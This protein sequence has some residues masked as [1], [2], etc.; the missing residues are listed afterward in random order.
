MFEEIQI[1]EL[2]RQEIIIYCIKLILNCFMILLRSASTSQFVLGM[3]WCWQMY[4]NQTCATLAK[5]M[6]L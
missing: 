5:Y 4:N 1:K 6:P 2:D 3:L